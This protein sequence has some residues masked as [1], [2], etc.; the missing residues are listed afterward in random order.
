MTV[1]IVNDVAGLGC[2]TLK[3]TRRITGKSRGASVPLFDVGKCENRKRRQMQ[4]RRGGS[5]KRMKE[6][7]HG[8]PTRR[9]PI[10]LCSL[11]LFEP[12][13]RVVSV[14]HGEFFNLTHGLYPAPFVSMEELS[15]SRRR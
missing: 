9:G 11:H 12:Y 14:G 6:S 7:T 8:V 15:D 5:S 2:W 10:D 4:A 1:L 3:L 13:L